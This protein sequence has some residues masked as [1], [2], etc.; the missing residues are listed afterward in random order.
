MSGKDWKEGKV[1]FFN[2]TKGYGF[3]IPEE[4]GD[5]V[6]VHVK[7]LQRCGYDHLDQD[8]KVEYTLEEHRGRMVAGEIRTVLDQNSAEDGDSQNRASG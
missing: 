6:F 4:G 8:Q 1:K 7:A 2:E 3:I 5:D